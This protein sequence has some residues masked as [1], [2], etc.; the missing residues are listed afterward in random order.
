MRDRIASDTHAAG[1]IAWNVKRPPAI[2]PAASRA[3][4]RTRYESALPLPR[5]NQSY[6]KKERDVPGGELTL[7]REQAEG[8]P[9][10]IVR[11]DLIRKARQAE[12]AS[13]MNEWLSSPGLQARK[14]RPSRLAASFIST[15]VSLFAGPRR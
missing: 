15:A 1:G 5:T 3:Q 11:D 13:R 10:G 12:T 7:L 6:G 9:P 14:L 2:S 8:L 4:N